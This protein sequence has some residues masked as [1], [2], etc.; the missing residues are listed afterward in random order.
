MFFHSMKV[1]RSPRFNAVQY[2]TEAE[3]GVV[4]VVGVHEV[5]RWSLW[6]LQVCVIHP[7]TGQDHVHL[8]TRNSN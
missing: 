5:V 3:E 1:R 4:Y 2:F 7:Q 8:N 6:V